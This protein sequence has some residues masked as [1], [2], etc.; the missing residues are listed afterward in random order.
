[1][2]VSPYFHVAVEV[3]DLDEA[4]ARFGRIFGVDF[5]P[6]TLVRSLP[7]A[8]RPDGPTAER[9]ATYSRQGPPYLE[10]MEAVPDEDGVLREGP[11]HIGLFT[12]DLAARAAELAGEGLVEERRT[13]TASGATTIWINRPESF[14]GT[15]L[16][17]FDQRMER[18]FTPDLLEEFFSERVRTRIAH[19]AAPPGTAPGRDGS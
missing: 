16:E 18:Y 19:I 9:L 6:P 5:Y 15:R 11:H 2:T 12:P 4:M 10:L 1:V 8:D 7:P 13:V 17:L 14:F 3:R